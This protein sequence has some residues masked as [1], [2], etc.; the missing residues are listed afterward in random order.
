MKI[1]VVSNPKGGSG[2]T[3]VAVNVAGW[4]AARRQRVVLADMDRQAS[5]LRWLGRRPALLPPIVGWS[6]ANDRRPGRDSETDWVVIDAP[7]GVHGEELRDLVRRADIFLVP[8][9]PSQLD[10]EAT[11]DFLG[12]LIEYKA[13]RDRDVAVGLI[14]M[15]V[16]SRT[17]SA[18]E[19]EAFLKGQPFPLVTVLRDT[20]IYV[21][22]ARDG[23]S[24]FDLP[25]SRGEQDWEQWKPLTRW[26]SRHANDA[27][28][29]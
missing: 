24:V 29:R 7:A 9:S 16:D 18:G 5:A 19:L 26:I 27:P 23:F 14:G 21:Y 3:T 20:Q 11:G 6:P 13:I 10:I 17:R 4:L 28:R 15:R 22:C 1:L 2:K 25:R 12:K 8:V